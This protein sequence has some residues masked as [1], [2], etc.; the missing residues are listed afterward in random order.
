MDQPADHILRLEVRHL[1]EPQLDPSV[2][3]SFF[4]VLFTLKA[5]RGFCLAIT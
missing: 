2:L 4:S 5:I 3:S 1:L